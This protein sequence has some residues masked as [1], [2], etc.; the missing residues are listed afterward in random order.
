MTE[1]EKHN[2]N[3]DFLKAFP[4]AG[5]NNMTLDQY[6]NLNR[7]DSFCYWIEFKTRI[8]GSIKGGN[9][10]KFGIYR[11]NK[12]PNKTKN[13]SF[14]DKYAWNVNLGE[15]S[16][17]A[18]EKVKDAI[19]KIANYG[20]E[21]N[22]K[23]I[24]DFKS[25]DVFW[26]VVKWKIAFLYSNENIIPYYSL[27]RLKI[28]ANKKG[29]PNVEH[30]TIG[31][32]QEFLIDKR[33]GLPIHEYGKQLDD[34][35]KEYEKESSSNNTPDNKAVQPTVKEPTPKLTPSPK[36]YWFLVARPKIW[37]LTDMNT[38]EV[39][40]YSLFNDKGKKRRV[41]QNFLD[42]KKGDIVIGYEATPTK[43]IV[44][45]AEVEKEN[46]G[47]QISFKKTKTLPSP[48]SFFEFSSIEEL[49]N[50]EF[51]KNPQGSLFKLTEDEYNVLMDLIRE[52]NPAR[53]TLSANTPYTEKNFL[54]DV[55]ITKDSYDR[56]KALL[57]TKK[58]IIL[59]GAPGVGKT[60]SAKK[61]A[62]SI[63]GEIDK[64]RVEFIQ[65]HQSY[66]YEEFIMGYKP[67]EEGGFY[68]KKGVF[69][70]F[71]KTAKADPDRPY[72]FIIDEINRG[73]M[74][75]IF[76]ELL[77]LIEN[78][79]RGEMVKLAYRDELFSV[80]ENLYIIGMMNTA[81][82]SLAMIDY[83]LRRRFGF[84]D[85]KPGFES[86]GFKKYQASLNSDLFNKAIN[87][88]ASLNKEIAKDD[89]LGEGFCIGHSY[90]CNQKTFSENWLKNVVDYDIIPMLR[91]YWFDNN[92]QFELQV[93]NLKDIFK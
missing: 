37:S 51:I 91:E 1:E 24:Q 5:L 21:K 40:N 50:M 32:I 62:Y 84:I 28:I 93:K 57:L 8:L 19:V 45:L 35:Y 76:G 92:Q 36:R 63:M 6:T 46:D 88:I 65:F 30:A 29:M 15:T 61:L 34:I 85:M 25:G 73:N 49:K 55:Y 54:N 58:N 56:M 13:L 78:Q 75:K 82:R 22:L 11:Y 67:N 52:T 70:N 48:I 79:Y 14:D 89:S 74:S 87:A 4:L 31:E 64:S 44:A 41:F 7:E 59:Q 18:F 26:D 47:E 77:M 2:L 38:G 10:F 20:N 16:E 33:G 12:K 27:D 71:C 23:A 39:Q 83:A 42:A 66:S 81:D 86:E 53:T 43:K 60:F 80:P 69:Y 9:S 17:E 68:L 90:F 3:Q 72:F